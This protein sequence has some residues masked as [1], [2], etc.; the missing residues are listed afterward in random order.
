MYSNYINY[1]KDIDYLNFNNCEFKRNDNYTAILEHVN[2]GTGLLYLNLIQSEFTNITEKQ[3]IDFITINDTYGYPH[4]TDYI[5]KNGT[6]IN[7][8]PSSLRYIYH[9]LLILDHYKTTN[10]N[11][12]V[13][14]GCGYGGLFLAICFFSN[15]LNIKINKYYLIDLP[16]VCNLIKYYL[17][18][19][20]NYIS[21]DYEL[22]NS[23]NIVSNLNNNNLFFISNYCF[24]ELDIEYR[25]YYINNL[26][27][28][29]TSGF[30]IWQTVFGYDLSHVSKLFKKYY[31][32][33][34][35]PQTAPD[36]KN[37]Y[38]LF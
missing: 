33:E 13:E 3:I 24:T 14:L 9:A 26:L 4:K 18:I 12:I 28:K 23:D 38:I 31:V 17:E 36:N 35:K 11:D 2:S 25:N 29:C 20:K 7:C 21:I 15:Y 6:T 1:I 8:S 27:P 32:I 34:E 19:N 5:L 30:I 16:E 10:T 22:C 37:Y